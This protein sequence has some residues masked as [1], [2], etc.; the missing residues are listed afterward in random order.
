M[1]TNIDYQYYGEYPRA[2]RRTPVDITQRVEQDHFASLFEAIE[3]DCNIELYG[4]K[5]GDYFESPNVHSVTYDNS[6][7]GGGTDTNCKFTYWLADP[8]TYYG[9]YNANAVIDAHHLAIV[10]DCKTNK[11][12]NDGTFTGYEA[13]RL[14]AWLKSSE[15]LAAIKEDIGY[16]LT[17]S[18][19]QGTTGGAH[20]AE[21]SKLFSKYASNAF[22]WGWST[23][24]EQISALT[25]MDIYGAPVWSGT[26]MISNLPQDRFQQGEAIKQL[27][28]FRKY[29]FNRLFGNKSIWLRSN[30]DASSACHAASTG[31]AGYSAFS[32][33]RGAVGLILLKA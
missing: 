30:R 13:S 31:N 33:A 14:H 17:G 16:I 8:D 28:I 26:D 4:Y 20:L 23:N 18:S 1:S 22:T 6:S 5:I 12:W 19:G 32:N 15:C 24:P 11:R 3:D 10:V 9:G 29:R 27:E 2:N 21:H 25:E 7:S